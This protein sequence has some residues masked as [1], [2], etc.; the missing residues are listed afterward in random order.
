MEVFDEMKEL[1]ISLQ[2]Q[3]NYS[4][5]MA[6]SIRV[7]IFIALLFL[8]ILTM[9]SEW[10]YGVIIAS[11]IFLIQYFKLVE[12]QRF[13]ITYL[14]I[15]NKS[16]VINYYD[17]NVKRTLIGD[18]KDFEFKKRLAFLNRSR[19]PYLLICYKGNSIIKQFELGN[20][21]EVLFKKIVL[22]DI[23]I[24]TGAQCVKK[25]EP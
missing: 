5:R 6:R 2:Q 4:K 23:S 14:K 9:F 17:T 13:F 8:L 3:V 21:D 18:L 12:S 22:Y 16:V 10:Y 25:I 15:E 1:E 20:W 24:S 11:L 7:I 19:T